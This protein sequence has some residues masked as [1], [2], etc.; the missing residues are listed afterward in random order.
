MVN[1]LRTRVKSR[2]SSLA[3]STAIFTATLT[4][5]ALSIGAI[6]EL[7]PGGA[8]KQ[9]LLAWLLAA[10]ATALALLAIEHFSNRKRLSETHLSHNRLRATL[11]AGHSVAWDLDLKTGRDV[12]FGDL[13]TI[14]EIP[15]DTLAVRR[16]D[17]YRFVHPD[18]RRRVAEE[19]DQARRNRSSYAAVFRVVHEDGAIRWVS[20]TG[21]FHYSRKGKP[22]RMLGIAV[23]ITERR[24]NQ[25][26]LTKSEERFS[27]A[28]RTGPVS[29]TLTSALD[30]R[31]LDVNETFEEITGWTRDETI[32]RTPF[33]INIWVD[34][35]EREAFAKRVLTEKSI[36]NF[37]VHYQRKNGSQ[38][39]GLASAECME[40]AGEPLIL[41]A[42]VDITDRKRTEDELRIKQ[43]ELAESQQL[44]HLGSWTWDLKNQK[45]TWSEEMSRVHGFD[46]KLPPPRY[47]ELSDLFTRESWDQLRKEMED[48][49][50]T[51]MVPEVDLEII[52]PD[53]SRRWV[54]T[55]GYAVR[56]ATGEVV[57]LHGTT[58]DI[59]ERKRNEE[60]LRLKEHDLAEAQRL[61]HIGSWDWTI[62]SGLI[63]WSE[64]LYRIHG[65]DP[66][67]PAPAF[68]DL[69][70]VYTPET[71]NRLLQ[72]MEQRSF[73]DMDLELIRPDGT[74]RWIHTVFEV[75]RDKDGTITT[76]RGVSRDITEEKQAR[77][78]LR[79]SEERMKAI[80]SS[81][82]DAIIAVGEEQRIVLFNAAAEGM[83]RCSANDAIGTHVERFMP[84]PFR[85]SEQL[86]GFAQ[87][88]V[89]NRSMG[90]QTELHA[91][92]SNG[93]PFPIEA[94]ISQAEN[95]GKKLFTVI[96]RDITERLRSEAILHESEERFRRVIEHIG[97]A[98]IVDDVGG[99]AV[100][101]NDRFLNLFGFTRE[102]LPTL[103]LEDYIVPESRA[104]LRDRHDRRVRGESVPSHFE[105]QGLRTDGTRMWLEVDVVPVT[106]SE[107]KI[108]GTQSAVR[109]ITERKRAQQ[110][111][112]DSEERLRHLIDASNDWVYEMD[113]NGVYTYAGPQCREMLGYEPEEFVGKRPADFMPPDEVLRLTEFVRNVFLKPRTFSGTKTT[114]V[115]KD[116][117]L[118]V[119]E[120]SAV[121]VYDKNGE[122]CGYRGMVRDITERERAEKALRQ[123]EARFRRVVEHI[124]DA[125][126]VDNV[127]GRL[128]FANEQFLQLF[129]FRPDE[130]E[131]IMLEDYVAPEYRAELRDRHNRRMRGEEVPTQYEC[132]GL[133]RDGT[134]LWLETNIVVIRDGDGSILG[135][136]KVLRDVTDR[137]RAE[138]ALH[139]S[140]ERFR[141]VANQA[142]V[143]IWMAGPDKLCNYFNKSWLEFTGRPV[144]A[145]L[146][147]GWTEGVHPDDSNRCL[148][149]YTEGFD[150]RESFEVQYRL[151]RYDA[152]YRWIM[153][154]GVPRF[155][156][157]GTFAG[158]IG[159][160]IDITERK[161][162][163]ESLATIGRRLI[164]AHEEERTWIGRE[165][166]DDINQRLALL[167]VELDQWNHRVHS[168]ELNAQVRHAQERISEIAKDVQGLSHRL[169]SSKLEYLGL[170]TAVNS[171]CR[172]LSE[173][174]KVEIRFNHA[175]IPRTLP[176]EVSLCLFR[177]SQE[178]LQNAVKH[179]GAR[180]FTVDL[181]GSEE[182]IE[183][184][185]SDIGSGFEE[186]EA[187]TRHGLGL[188]SMRERLQLVRGELSVKSKPGAG[189][190][191][192][193]RVPFK[194]DESRAMAG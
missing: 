24:K 94:S 32:G 98:I 112:H 193:A 117:H 75:A 76:L 108:V 12:W 167:A 97:D 185:V 61:A 150:R 160:C 189:T 34:P 58:Q 148:Q 25:E 140:E 194:S 35:A 143:L 31:Y 57:C 46:P 139:E 188:I 43:S 36:R 93:E 22:L 105:Q 5:T 69:S 2:D 82:M 84:L 184:T 124:G 55:R 183:L 170:A 159:S 8:H 119:C 164:E 100:F 48:S 134:R 63:K 74:R 121:P 77:D 120:T 179:S 181:H 39:V 52:R 89:T 66:T 85:S 114:R 142:P 86:K 18:D 118:V 64:E 102:Q 17:F 137:K 99:K 157:D 92:R 50:R 122:F 177:V 152:E 73:P 37:E 60:A 4:L 1:Q 109:D 62:A 146:G 51:G 144:E 107:G 30:H 56:D 155:D 47:E 135:S 168:A 132:E 26:A 40:I 187:F 29:M 65:L 13:R 81:A 27:R 138:Q 133:R 130:I 101:A 129:G 182:A 59:T 166:H 151:R 95:Q 103:K 15:S 154:K 191:I 145:E 71:W 113:R 104:E 90:A 54:S 78:Q 49:I 115:H 156:P 68:E 161:L 127:Q 19:V 123:S 45:L 38:G 42:V 33:D 21:E 91:L 23:D 10:L 41:S 165:L 192:H 180:R 72:A 106:N 149:A 11:L 190:T 88:D 20:A 153:D 3:W 131:Q 128:L 80:V 83:F 44:A 171:F 67:Q 175:G 141:L 87:T 116:G 163:E 169:H 125:L 174:S 9:H 178:A 173:Q 176:K 96:I 79:E 158:Y 70:K 147:Y 111:I 172:E 6:W 7:F 110:A 162:A 136:Q 186:Q 16:E 14:F 126:A 53:G 28:F